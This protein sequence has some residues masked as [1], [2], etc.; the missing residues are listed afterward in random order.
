M[1][2]VSKFWTTSPALPAVPCST[3]SKNTPM[4]ICAMALTAVTVEDCNS[5][6]ESDFLRLARLR[7]LGIGG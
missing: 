3:K 5:A 7:G 1:K 4:Q 6:A 2:D